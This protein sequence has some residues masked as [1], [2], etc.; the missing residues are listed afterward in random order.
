MKV[1]NYT[2]KALLLFILLVPSIISAQFVIENPAGDPSTS[3]VADD[4][5]VCFDQGATLD[6]RIIATAAVTDPNLTINLATGVY[7]QWIVVDSRG[8]SWQGNH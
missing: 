8:F 1:E 4:V 5:N 7:N 6:F 2:H 3:A